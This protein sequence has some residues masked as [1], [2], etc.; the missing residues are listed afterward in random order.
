MGSMGEDQPQQGN[1]AFEPP[2]AL[3]T[4]QSAAIDQAVNNYASAKNPDDRQR[5]LT[6]LAHASNRLAAAS[7]SPGVTV[8]RFAFQPVANAAVRVAVGMG[9]FNQLP[10]S[11]KPA[12]TKE[13]A[14]KC[15]SDPEF[16]QRIAR[17]VA[18]LGFLQETAEE[19]YAHTPVSLILT[20]DTAQASLARE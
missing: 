18:S 13:L 6:T 8:Q 7:A 11:G 5:A 20:D 10:Q 2:L 19:T 14:A 4:L 15:N 12:T 17:A 3:L 1:N 16:V 9:L